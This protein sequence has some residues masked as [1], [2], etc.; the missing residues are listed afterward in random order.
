M[1]LEV[2]LL[3]SFE[4]SKGLETLKFFLRSRARWLKEGDAN[5]IFFHAYVN[6]RSR[7][8]SILALNVRDVWLEA[9]FEVRQATIDHF[10]SHFRD[11]CFDHPMLD[12][13]SFSFL[14]D[15]DNANLIAPF[16][17]Y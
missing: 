12:E 16:L 3:W 2:R 8:N 17:L 13:V 1:S 9:V 11:P 5:T 10:S 14:L 7:R 15:G 6:S 4:I